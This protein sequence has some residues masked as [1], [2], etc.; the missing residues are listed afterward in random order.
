M[1][2]GFYSYNPK[3]GAYCAVRAESL[4]EIQVN[5][6]S[7]KGRAMAQEV[8]RRPLTSEAGVPSQTSLR[9]ICGGNGGSRAGFFPD[10]SVFPSVTLH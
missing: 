2:I 8:S 10:T 4:N 9:E 5:L 6:K 1:L 7:L 3:Q